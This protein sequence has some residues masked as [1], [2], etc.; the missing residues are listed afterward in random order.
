[1]ASRP[2]VIFP[3]SIKDFLANSIQIHFGSM[4]MDSDSTTSFPDST[5]AAS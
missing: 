3:K 4:L 1:M 2:S 5:S